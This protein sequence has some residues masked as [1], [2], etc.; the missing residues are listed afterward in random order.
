MTALRFS[1]LALVALFLAGIGAILWFDPMPVSAVPEPV[2]SDALLASSAS[3]GMGQL[4]PQLALAVPAVDP[5]GDGKPAVVALAAKATATLRATSTATRV[6][7]N[8]PTRGPTNTPG[9]TRTPAPTRTP[10]LAVL[11]SCTD[12]SSPGSY[13]LG[14][15][16]NSGGDCIN[17][18]SS[19][20]ILDCRGQSITG[21]GWNG[22]GIAVRNLGLLGS[23]RPS[24]IEIRGCN[25]SGFNYGIYAE[26]GNSLYIHDNNVSS[27]FPDVDQRR[28]GKFLG[29]AEGGGIRLNNAVGGRVE[30]NTTNQQAIGID[31]RQSSGVKIR[32]NTSS[33]NTAWGIDLYNTSGS[34]VSG[35]TTAGNIRYCTWGA[36]VVGPGCDAG[37]IIM[38]MG[39]SNN[40]IA[41]NQVGAGNGNGIFQ[42]AHAQP[43]GNNNIITGNRVDGAL[44]N[45]IEMGFCQ[46]TQI[47]GN[48]L[49]NGLDGIWMG[50]AINTTIKNNTIANH[51]NHGIIIN[52]SHDNTIANNTLNNDSEAIYIYWEPVPASAFG[53]L[54]LNDYRT[55]NNT[56]TG[57]QITNNTGCGIH[58]KDSVNSQLTNN[59]LLNN[60]RNWWFEGNTDGNT[61]TGN[62][63]N[64]WLGS[65]DQMLALFFGY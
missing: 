34:E 55:Y 65:P 20:V 64:S 14:G 32:G 36:G 38:Q 3:L 4:I 35:N 24:N 37:G 11:N 51:R 44:Y 45:S 12:I 19:N 6:P 31:V 33:G 59:T 9:P 23:Q 61:I 25:I 42:K 1:L 63:D 30:N 46:G 47:T 8:A 54:N 7:T 16:L 15:P 58:L 13:S 62:N 43:C 10:V 49:T 17:I 41:N 5:N 48:T 28:Y 18:R 22:Y 56:V 52:P 60:G 21:Q 27:N 26:S 53:W 50:F 29:M 39:A 2:V 57:N 40:L